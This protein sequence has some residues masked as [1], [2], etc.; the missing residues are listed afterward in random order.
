VPEERLPAL[1]VPPLQLSPRSAILLR[2]EGMAD[3]V[4]WGAVVPVALLPQQTPAR[5]IKNVRSA[6]QRFAALRSLAVG[7]PVPLAPVAVVMVP[8]AVEAVGPGPLQEHCLFLLAVSFAEQTP[9]KAS[10]QI[11]VASAATEVRLWLETVGEAV[12]AAEVQAD[13]FA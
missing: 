8:L 2:V 3:P 5:F 11:S 4:D 10:C 1:R 12:E 13:I 9:T 6:S 7:A